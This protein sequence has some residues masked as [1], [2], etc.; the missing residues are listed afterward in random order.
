MYREFGCCD[1]AKDQDLRTKF[2][3]IMGH[4]DYHDYANCASYVHELLCQVGMHGQRSSHPTVQAHFQ[5]QHVLSSTRA[6]EC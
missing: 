3:R 2:Y 1:D 5:S 6:S 4:F